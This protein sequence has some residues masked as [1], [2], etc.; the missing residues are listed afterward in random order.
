MRDRAVIT[1]ALPLILTIV[2]HEREHGKGHLICYGALLPLLPQGLIDM[3]D[4]LID[5]GIDETV[6]NAMREMS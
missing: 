4:M 2:R 3:A 1:W 5:C 6:L